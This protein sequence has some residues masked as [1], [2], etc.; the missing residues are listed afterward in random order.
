MEDATKIAEKRNKKKARF[1]FQHEETKNERL[2]ERL[3]AITKEYAALYLVDLAITSAQIFSYC[4]L[5]HKLT[6]HLREL[7]VNNNFIDSFPDVLFKLTNLQV[8]NISRN[9]VTGPLP[10]AI[11]QLSALCHLNISYNNISALPDTIEE[12]RQ[13]DTFIVEGNPELKW[14]PG[15]LKKFRDSKG[16]FVL[17]WNSRKDCEPLTELERSSL[18]K[19]EINYVPSLKQLSAEVFLE[20]FRFART[21]REQTVLQSALPVDIRE[22]LRSGGYRCYHCG[23]ARQG[24]APLRV[25][26]TVDLTPQY[27][28][29]STRLGYWGSV[30]SRV[31]CLFCFDSYWC[32][33]RACDREGWIPMTD[34]EGGL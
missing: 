33:A 29:Y 21:E 23:K 20:I 9:C 13:L 17:K 30:P 24:E 12:L 10:P 26:F 27:S 6:H 2:E 5:F 16:K 28:V 4:S 3:L 8:L 7:Y 25:L 31:P 1:T 14:L 34:L 19:F 22:Y 11:S 32:Y 15:A 18:Q